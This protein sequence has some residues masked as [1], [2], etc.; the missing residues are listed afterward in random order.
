M[1][2]TATQTVQFTRLSV[3]YDA[4]QDRLRV[5]AV[6]PTGATCALWL[7]RRLAGGLLPALANWLEKAS[8]A[9]AAVPQAV[10]EQAVALESAVIA[11]RRARD[12]APAVP[13]QAVPR[14]VTTIDL[15]RQGPRWSL[16]FKAD[17]DALH[18]QP[19]Q[20]QLNCDSGTVHSLVQGLVQQVKKAQWNDALAL[21]W[22]AEGAEPP[23]PA[24]G[25]LLN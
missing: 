6:D 11:G 5:D 17:A 23:K 15:S 21:G 10:R 19:L 13:P 12:P 25:T 7:T 8:P 9:A 24:P 4:G 22:L 1:N 2:E 14:L 16:V 3:R 20:G 18:A